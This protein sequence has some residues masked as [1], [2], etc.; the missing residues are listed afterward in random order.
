[1][2]RNLKTRRAKREIRSDSE[3]EY[4]PEPEPEPAP[5]DRPRL[6]PVDKPPRAPTPGDVMSLLPGMIQ[7]AVSQA[8]TPLREEVVSLKRQNADLTTQLV[9]SATQLDN[10]QEAVDKVDKKVTEHQSNENVGSEKP[11]T[12]KPI[13]RP[14]QKTISGF[15][16]FHS[17]LIDRY[18]D[19]FFFV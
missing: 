18:V 2:P 13:E 3:S 6:K 16:R 9:K 12:K 15:R 5:R 10:V 7:A 17:T 1:M 19:V 11:D 14:N 4:E 8:I